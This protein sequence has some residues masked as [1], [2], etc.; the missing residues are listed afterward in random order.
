MML[1][2]VLEIVQSYVADC[3][4]FSRGSFACNS[5]VANL[6]ALMDGRDLG[7]PRRLDHR[8]R[9]SHRPNCDQGQGTV[10]LY[11]DLFAV[12]VLF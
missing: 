12:C 7:R 2:M 5:C 9:Y 6:L 11:I 8:L 1:H 4:A 3:T 10:Y